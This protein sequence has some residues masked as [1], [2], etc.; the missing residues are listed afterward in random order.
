MSSISVFPRVGLPDNGADILPVE[1]LIPLSALDIFQVAA[2]RSALEKFLRL[3]TADALAIKKLPDSGWIDLPHFRD[4]EGLFEIRK[5]AEGGHETD[6][7]FHYILY[8]PFKIEARR[9]VVHPGAEDGIAMKGAPQPNGPERLPLFEFPG[10]EIDVDL[11]RSFVLSTRRAW[12]R[13]IRKV[14]LADP[15]ACPKCGGRLRI[16]AFIEDPAVIE[17]ILRHLQLWQPP[18]RPPPPPSSRTLEPDEDF[19][20]WEARGRLLDGID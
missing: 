16:I 8:K 1:A 14:Y 15:L 9:Q 10:G 12:A 19:L 2:D 7:L 3:F 17:K 5:I 6:V 18:E 11:F 4:T 20:A 13:L